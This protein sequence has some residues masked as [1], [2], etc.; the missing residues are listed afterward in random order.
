M[1]VLLHGLR[2]S[3]IATFDVTLITMS[4]DMCIFYP[5]ELL[6]HD[7][8]GRP[9]D[10]FIYKKFENSKLCLLTATQ[11]Y[12]KRRAEYIAHTKFLFTTVSPYGP[13]HKDAIAR[14]M[15]NTLTQAEVN[16]DIFSSHSCR[17]SAS[18]K[19][20]NMGVDLDNIL[21]MGCWSRQ[22]TFLE[23]LFKRVRIHGHK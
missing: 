16:T 6:K 9:R 3:T 15:K 13:P 12:L 19:A 4:N 20:N 10:E 17:S 7:R 1:L 18:S 2:I 5:S 22:S 21:K 11:E 23:V 14:W 8:Q